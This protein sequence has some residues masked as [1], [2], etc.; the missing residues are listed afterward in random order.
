[1]SKNK[2]M[3][4]PIYF[5][6][7]NRALSL[8]K[9]MLILLTLL[10]FISCNKEVKED[11]ISSNTDSFKSLV[12]YAKGFDIQV[13]ETYKKLIIKSPYPGAENRQEFILVDQRVQN[14]D[15]FIDQNV[16][17]IPF[18]RIVTTSTTHIPMLELIEEE[19]SLI[20]FPH[21]SYISSSKTRNLIEKGKVQE[22]G[23]E[24]DLNTELLISLNPD[25]VI[26]FSMGNNMK[27]YR[28]IEKNNIPVIYNSEWLEETP[29]GRAEWIK[30][31]GTL[32]DKDKEADSI[33]TEIEKKYNNAVKIAKKSNTKPGILTGVLYKD[34]WN[35]PAGESFTATLL[36][37]AN[38]NYYW[39]ETS[40]QGSL[41]L[42]FEAV[43][44]K[45][46]RAEFWIGSGYF[47]NYDDLASANSHY[48]EFDAFKRKNVYTFSKRRGENGGVLYYELAP[49]QP[50]IVLQDII[51]ITH[52]DLLPNY[53]PFFLEKLDKAGKETED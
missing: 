41:V 36:K 42:S 27:M 43:Y 8:F 23:N 29:L 7:K 40:G 33:F 15:K 24:Q 22:I 25:A 49:V 37:D 39:K 3:I 32:F 13:F 28:I 38:T 53:K 1:M 18:K 30:F 16:L 9:N 21:T 19:T 46:N 2:S 31:F 6:I 45:A 35:L 26:G 52:P 20:G 48:K 47:T 17:V 4:N 50:H 14:T 12:K 5:N 44:D 34:K 51:K 11:K 10:W